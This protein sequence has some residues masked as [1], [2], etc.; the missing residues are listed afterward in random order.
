MAVNTSNY[1]VRQVCMI[2]SQQF[3]FAK[4]VETKK[5]KKEN[6]KAKVVEEL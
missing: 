6:E 4:K 1:G 5:D 3:Y 2:Q